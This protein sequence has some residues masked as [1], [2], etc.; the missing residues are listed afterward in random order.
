MSRII[1]FIYGGERGPSED[2]YFEVVDATEATGDQ[3]ND[4]LLG[5]GMLFDSSWVAEWNE[6]A[7]YRISDEAWEALKHTH[8]EEAYMDLSVVH[9]VATHIAGAPWRNEN[10]PPVLKLVT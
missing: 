5:Y 3:D 9:D 1:S 8:R 7:I 10:P 4:I 6:Y 2:E